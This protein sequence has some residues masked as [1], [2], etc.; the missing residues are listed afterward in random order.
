ME[1]QV[2]LRN[3]ILYSREHHQGNMFPPQIMSCPDLDMADSFFNDENNTN[4]SRDSP[5]NQIVPENADGYLVNFDIYGRMILDSPRDELLN[6]KTDNFTQERHF[7]AGSCDAIEEEEEEITE[8]SADKENLEEISYEFV[9]RRRAQS[10]C[11]GSLPLSNHPRFN[12]RRAPLKD[13]TPMPTKKVKVTNSLQVKLPLSP[14][15]ETPITNVHS[16]QQFLIGMR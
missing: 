3:S 1:R 11:F 4:F 6:Q 10:D 9:A 2:N 14:I 7:M 15:M 16:K 12:S 5:A 13:I 8:V